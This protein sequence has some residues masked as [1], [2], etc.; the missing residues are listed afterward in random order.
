MFTSIFNDVLGPIMRGPS[1]SHTAGSYH[2]GLAT[3]DLLGA[4]PKRV[5]ITFDTNSSYAS[6]YV[7][8]GVDQA[9]ITGLMGWKQTDEIFTKA[10]TTAKA[11]GV[12]IDFEITTLKHADHPNYVI[13]EIDGTLGQQISVHAKSVGGGTFNIISV[14]NAQVLLDGKAYVTLVSI[15]P[16]A[17]TDVQ[18]FIKDNYPQARV[19]TSLRDDQM[20]H[21][22]ISSSAPLSFDKMANRND[23]YK[24]RQAAPVYYAQ[25]NEPL[26]TSASG[27]VQFC[28]DN[29]CS[30]GEA[31]LEYEKTVLGISE[32]AAIDE[33]LYRYSVMKM[34]VAVGL[35]DNNVDM[36]LLEPMAGTIMNS[37]N[38][39]R[40]AIGGIHAKAGAAAMAAMHTCNSRGVVC[41]APT[42]GAAG[43]LPGV[44]TALDGNFDLSKRQ[45]ALLLFAAGGVGLILAIRGTF[46][47]EVAGC[48]VEIGAAGAMASAAVVEF[49][50]GTPE[51]ACDAAA[52]S[53][54]NTMGSVCDLV[55]GMCEIPCHTRNAAAASNAFTNADMVLG[56][57]INHI[58]LDQTI[59]AVYSSGLLL[60]SE[61]R[62]TAKGGLAI[63]PAAQTLSRKN[64]L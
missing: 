58:N 40:V 29:E 34:S 20:C 6:T 12:Q 59:D 42:G 52:I 27:L 5:K 37:I 32:Q 7:Q 62:C 31:M 51:Q 46:A 17:E 21:M 53:F 18:R 22:Q 30:L 45:L 61:L 28:R 54:Q 26:F 47:A 41:A 24:I 1:S 2:I 36:L 55:Q 33:M 16:E 23:V 13:I 48:Q 63:T 57:Y 50:G 60:P 43:T 3:R 15:K 44:L 64:V 38:A 49:A 14:D 56:G 25:K 9:F 11:Q 10:C 19:D 35:I 39:Q 8:Q 4:E